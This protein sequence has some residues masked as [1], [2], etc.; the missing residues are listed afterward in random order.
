MKITNPANE[1]SFGIFEGVWGGEN[2][3]SSIS[4]K[5]LN[6]EMQQKKFFH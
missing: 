6:D 4:S 5:M 3:R 1:R 2:L